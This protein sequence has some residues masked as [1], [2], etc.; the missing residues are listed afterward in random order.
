MKT[1]YCSMSSFSSQTTKKPKV[2]R[3]RKPSGTLKTRV[4]ALPEGLTKVNPRR[5]QSYKAFGLGKFM[6]IVC[7]YENCFNTL[8]CQEIEHLFNT[9]FTLVSGKANGGRDL[10]FRTT[11]SAETFNAEIRRLF[12]RLTTYRLCKAEGK[13]NVLTHLS[14][15]TPA[16]IQRKA[17]LNKSALYVQATGVSIILRGKLHI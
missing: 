4:C 17:R 14:Y 9:L 6:L 8:F 7:V 1:N 3:G 2:G 16:D 15:N 11:L 5:L 13:D 12:P 10:K